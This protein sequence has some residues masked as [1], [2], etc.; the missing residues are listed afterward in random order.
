MDNDSTRGSGIASRWGPRGQPRASRALPSHTISFAFA[1]NDLRDREM[2]QDVTGKCAQTATVA[3]RSQDRRSQ[4]SVPSWPRAGR[5]SSSVALASCR[6][7]HAHGRSPRVSATVSMTTRP[8]SI[9]SACAPRTFTSSLSITGPGGLQPFGLENCRTTIDA[10]VQSSRNAAGRLADGH[11]HALHLRGAPS[12]IAAKACALPASAGGRPSPSCSS[13]RA[14]SKAE[15]RPASAESL[16]SA[17]RT[18][19][20]S[21]A[22]PDQHVGTMPRRRQHQAQRDRHH[23]STR[24]RVLQSAHQ[25]PPATIRANA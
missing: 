3:L 14:S 19:T 25:S 11:A 20:R 1:G 24:Q 15:P 18:A 4:L 17:P 5:S 23:A 13:Q 6:V 7:S 8:S 12:S 2:H 22:T 10:A 9:V 16:P 21:R